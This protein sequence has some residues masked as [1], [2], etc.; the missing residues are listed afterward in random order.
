MRSKNA[1][2]NEEAR[3]LQSLKVVPI[4]NT[5]VRVI[6]GENPNELEIE[7]ELTYESAFKQI[8]KKA[9]KP[10]QKRRFILDGIGKRVYTSIDGKKTFEQIIDEFATSEKLTFFESRAL[11]GQYLQTLT[12][13]GLIAAS[14]PE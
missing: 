12:R 6:S 4:H 5:S 3:F 13:R 7:V 8:F 14:L 2:P 1:T 11:L 10:R 9:L